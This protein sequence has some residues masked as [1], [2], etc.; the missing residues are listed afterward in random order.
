MFPIVF[1]INEEKIYKEN[2]CGESYAM[3]FLVKY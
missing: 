1:E 2:C 3:L